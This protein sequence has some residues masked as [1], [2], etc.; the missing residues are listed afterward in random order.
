MGPLRLR[1]SGRTEAEWIESL[2]ARGRPRPPTLVLFAERPNPG[3]V[4]EAATRPVYCPSIRRSIRH[5]SPS[6]LERALRACDVGSSPASSGGDVSPTHDRSP[7]AESTRTTAEVQEAQRGT[8]KADTDSSQVRVELQAGSPCWRWANHAQ[9]KWQFI[10]LETLKLHCG[11]LPESETIGWSDKPKA[12][13]PCRD[14]FT[15]G[16][17]TQRTRWSTTGLKSGQSRA[18]TR[19]A[20]GTLT[21]CPRRFHRPTVAIEEGKPPPC[22]IGRSARVHPPSAATVSAAWPL[23]LS[24]LAMTAAGESSRR[25]CGRRRATTMLRRSTFFLSRPLERKVW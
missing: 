24:A 4:R 8:E 18:A 19:F 7:R 10:E 15:H 6:S 2:L 23:A 21:Q 12:T 11:R 9:A 1:H 3:G 17:S 13:L 25:N 14:A 20:P 16:R 22:R 5:E